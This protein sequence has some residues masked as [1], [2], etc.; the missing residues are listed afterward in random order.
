MFQSNQSR[1]QDIFKCWH[2]SE[3]M[4]Q[5]LLVPNLI[6]P[7]VCMFVYPQ[8]G[9]ERAMALLGD[10]SWSS[11]IT[12]PPSDRGEVVRTAERT[13]ARIGQADAV[14]ADTG[15]LRV[16]PLWRHDS[17][18]VRPRVSIR[19]GEKG[20]VWACDCRLPKTKRPIEVT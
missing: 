14:L 3:G 16:K 17:A 5:K 6:Q 1:C 7:L 10:C 20:D 11:L 8:A 4:I 19:A 13:P 2:A 15:Y 18:C 9:A 12:C